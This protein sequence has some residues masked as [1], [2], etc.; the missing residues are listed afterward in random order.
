MAPVKRRK[1]FSTPFKAGNGSIILHSK[2]KLKEEFQGC[3]WKNDCDLLEHFLVDLQGKV[4]SCQFNKCRTHWCM[5][6]LCWE[7]TDM[8][9]EKN[10][11]EGN[12]S[13]A[14]ERSTFLCEKRVTQEKWLPWRDL[15][16]G[17]QGV[18]QHEDTKTPARSAHHGSACRTYSKICWNC[19][20]KNG[21]AH[22]NNRVK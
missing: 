1:K 10:C 18:T 5:V 19:R 16:H 15:Q 11:V 8:C 12:N 4:W 9:Y 3:G 22:G 7:S 17:S 2:M 20:V 14:C 13:R 21:F 6:K